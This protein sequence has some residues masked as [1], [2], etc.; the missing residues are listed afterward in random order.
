[1][2]TSE[3]RLAIVG[4]GDIAQQHLMAFRALGASVVASANRSPEKRRKAEQAGIG[5][6]YV[7]PLMMVERE[8]P[9]GILLTTS[10]LSQ[11]DMVRK[12]MLCDVPL[13]IEKPPALSF[14]DWTVLRKQIEGRGVP[15][16]VGLNRRHYSVYHRALQY[17]GGIHSVTSVSVEWSED[18]QKMLDIGHPPEILPALNF[19]NSIHGLDLLVFFAGILRNPEIWG[20]NLDQSDRSFRWQMSVHG[21]TERGVRADFQSNWDAP[22]RWRLL[23][24]AADVRMVSSPLET[25]ILFNRGRTPKTIDPSPQDQRFKPGFYEQASTFLELVRGKSPGWPTASLDEVSADMHLAD[26]L[27]SACKES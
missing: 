9:D 1:M 24:D 2:I 16:M 15:I 5:Y 22:G 11:F 7:D 4:F 14:T 12:M 10:A 17:M 23:V 27:T 21:V 19:A 20:R 26:M 25:A 8:R 18:P 13:L 3:P 6:T